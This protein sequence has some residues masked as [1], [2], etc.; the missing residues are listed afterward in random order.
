MSTLPNDEPLTRKS[1]SSTYHEYK[2]DTEYLAG[3]LSWTS[4]QCGYTLILEP[5]TP[6]LKCRA[7][8]AA[9]L[10]T[11]KTQLVEQPQYTIKVTQFVEMAHAIVDFEPKIEVPAALQSVFDRDILSRTNV[12]R[13]FQSGHKDHGSDMRHAYSIGILDKARNLL[14]PLMPRQATVSEE[15][16]VQNRFAGL[17]V[18]ETDLL[19]DLVVEVKEDKLPRM[20][21][22]SVEQDEE[23]IE[24]NFFFAIASFLEDVN[25]VRKYIAGQ[26]QHY[27]T[28]GEG[29]TRV[30][31]L[32]NTASDLV[33]SAE[34]QF[35]FD[36]VR[37]QKYPAARFPV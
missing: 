17:T 20:T 25:D 2:K 32:S 29:L 30:A 18:E 26:W 12:S 34:K 22:V 10:S 1:L 15:V 7:R 27:K 23:G 9:K 6:R 36:I 31:L 13:W 3:W 35:E 14:R 21:P 16:K 8:K 19:D 11:P 28:T 5:K 4:Q 24:E 33:R 37:P